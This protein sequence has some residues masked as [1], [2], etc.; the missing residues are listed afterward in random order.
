MR[1]GSRPAFSLSKIQSK[2]GFFVYASDHM[3]FFQLLEEGSRIEAAFRRYFYRALPEQRKDSYE[4]L[5]CHAHVIR[6]FVCRALQFPP[7]G[8]I[9][10]SIPHASITWIRILPDGSVILQWFGNC[11]HFP[12]KLVTVGLEDK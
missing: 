12:P 7:Q 2:L 6:F 3:R 4:V 5:V 11:S 1:V 8:W 9:R 10:L